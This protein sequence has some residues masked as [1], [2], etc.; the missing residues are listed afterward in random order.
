MIF[1]F[2]A[3]AVTA[4]ACAALY[5]A[6]AGRMAKTSG[7]DSGTA[8]NHFR[9]VLAGIDADLA[10]GKLGEPEAVAAKGELAREL[11][12]QQA[13]FDAKAKPTSEL[14][15]GAI[16][17]CVG[18]IAVLSLAIYAVLGSPNLPGQ[19]LDDRA[20][21]AAQNIDINDAILRIERQLAATPDDLRGWSVIAP[22]YMQTGRLADAENAYRRVIALGGGNADVETSLAE[23]LMLQA[24]G[25]AAG[26]AMTLLQS[27][28]AS[29][30]THILSRLYIAAELTRTGQYDD[31]VAAW[32][33]VLA[34]SK[35]DESWVTAANEG[36]AVALNKGVMPNTT[37]DAAA[38]AQMVEGLDARLT[39]QGGAIEEWTQLVRAYVV[40][41]DL[42]KAQSAYDGALKAYPKAFDR[43]DLDTLALD[44]G[45]KGATP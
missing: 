37:P 21:V 15:R 42:I 13:E 31:A 3:I 35:G 24:N 19:H 10:S 28:A 5:F 1:W 12:R 33:A 18:A 6:A 8:N 14:G 29:D 40:L 45:L 43:G 11:L 39:A 41:G 34:L 7:P 20:D 4:I 26:E 38:I 22:V 27:A 17:A 25:S 30:P 23:T 9:Q 44:A 36:R 2:I 32:D 16:L